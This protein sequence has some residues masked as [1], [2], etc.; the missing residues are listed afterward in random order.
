MEQQNV[1]KE[2]RNWSSKIIARNYRK[3]EEL[4]RKSLLNN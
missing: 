4:R 2:L 3:L 1:K